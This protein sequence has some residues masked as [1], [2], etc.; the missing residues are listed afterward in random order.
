[1]VD[2]YFISIEFREH[3][4]YG[5]NALS[6]LKVHFMAPDS[7]CT[8]VNAPRLCHVNS[9]VSKQNS[10]FIV[11]S[12][13]SQVN[14]EAWVRIN[15]SREVE[16]GPRSWFHFELRKWEKV[17]H[18]E[19]L[20]IVLAQASS[21]W[22]VSPHAWVWSGRGG[23]SLAVNVLFPFPIY[24]HTRPSSV[25]WENRSTKTTSDLLKVTQ[26]LALGFFLIP[27]FHSL[28]IWTNSCLMRCDV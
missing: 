22:C 13:W 16:S 4:F 17:G 12:W 14:L 7:Q 8:A 3:S 21:T 15:Q 2:I 1:M 23:W 20:L 28:G 9:A 10:S 18:L 6:F 26:W 11:R 5:F 27:G 24:T 25:L 19:A